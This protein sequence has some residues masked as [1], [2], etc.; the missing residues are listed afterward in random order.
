MVF[1]SGMRHVFIFFNPNK[2]N[3]TKLTKIRTHCFFPG[4]CYDKSA[5]CKGLC[6][7][8]LSKKTCQ[9]CTVPYKGSNR[10]WK[11]LNR[12]GSYTIF[13]PWVFSRR[14]YTSFTDSAT[15]SMCASV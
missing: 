8:I 3:H 2:S 9:S 10:A 13:S 14:L 12:F 11:N 15:T 4:R 7:F 5:F 6:L 1:Y